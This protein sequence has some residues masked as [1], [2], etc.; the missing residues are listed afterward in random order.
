M[1]KEN[2]N[3]I[4]SSIYIY[5]LSGTYII[6]EVIRN[7][8]KVYM[9]IIIEVIRNMRKVYMYIIIIQYLKMHMHSVHIKMYT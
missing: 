3:D 1:V 4:D 9:Y 7:M 5:V 6:I 2:D 8:R